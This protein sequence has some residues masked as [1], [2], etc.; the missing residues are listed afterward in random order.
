MKEYLKTGETISASSSYFYITYTSF[1]RH[2]SFIKKLKNLS[3]IKI[4]TSTLFWPKYPFIIHL[5]MDVY[6]ELFVLNNL[7]LY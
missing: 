4:K 1:H 3:E 7:I 5:N 6:F 2:K